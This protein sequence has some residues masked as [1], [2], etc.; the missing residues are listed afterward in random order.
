M[1]R[2]HVVAMECNYQKVDRQ[3][4]E[5]FIN[6]LN[7]KYILEEIIKELMATKNGNHITSG[8]MLAW[9]KR[10]E[11]QKAQAAVLNS[12]TESKQFD[13]IKVSDKAK[14]NKARAPVNWA[15]Q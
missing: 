3:L 1:R 8:G 7:D 12:L 11:V 2:L 14:D 5:H 6:D 4:K 10:V 9:A 13:K 15:K